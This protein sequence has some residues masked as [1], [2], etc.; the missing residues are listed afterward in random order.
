MNFTNEKSNFTNLDVDS[1]SCFEKRTVNIQIS[2]IRFFI[3]EIRVKLHN[4]PKIIHA[5]KSRR[6]CTLEIA[7]L[8]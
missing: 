5:L 8:R 7:I 6:L 3:C 4:F 1:S 2:E